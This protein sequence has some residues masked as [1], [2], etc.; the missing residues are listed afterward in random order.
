MIRQMGITPEKPFAS[1][2]R[3]QA[4]PGKHQVIDLNA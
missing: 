1:H 2:L 4:D 3:V